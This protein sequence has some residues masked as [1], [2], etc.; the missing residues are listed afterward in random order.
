MYF[1]YINTLY[2]YLC[3]SLKERVYR[4]RHSRRK[5]VSQSQGPN[6]IFLRKAAGCQKTYRILLL[7]VSQEQRRRIFY[8]EKEIRQ[9]L[10]VLAL[11]CRN[12]NCV[13]A[14]DCV[15]RTTH[16]KQRKHRNRCYILLSQFRGRYRCFRRGI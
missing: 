11:G 8:D 12:D 1:I 7:R 10:S 9:T 5:P 16:L 2:Y 3:G 4:Q 15:C 14:G 13:D 6:R